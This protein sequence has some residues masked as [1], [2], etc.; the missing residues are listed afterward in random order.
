MVYEGRG[1]LLKRKLDTDDVLDFLHLHAKNFGGRKNDLVEAADKYLEEHL[2]EL[3][4]AYF[5]S[6]QE[7]QARASQLM[8][9]LKQASPS[10]AKDAAA[11]VENLLKKDAPNALAEGKKLLEGAISSKGGV[12]P[13]AVNSKLYDLAAACAS[14]G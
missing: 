7:G 14:K 10:I 13:P 2:E 1:L 12:T 3:N 11:F 4:G 9:E 6:L 8:Q 5:N